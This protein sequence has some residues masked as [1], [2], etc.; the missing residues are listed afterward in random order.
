MT[1]GKRP[2]F[3][4]ELFGQVT[5]EIEN[6]ENS[7]EPN[8][9]PQA[10]SATPATTDTPLAHYVRPKNFDDFKGHEEVF[11]RYKFLKGGKIPSLI[12]WGPPG[13]GKTTLAHLLAGRSGK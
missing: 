4:G 7:A 10:T 2:M 12:I 13:T 1:S 11:R 6:E 3:Q 8:F 5:S 9:H